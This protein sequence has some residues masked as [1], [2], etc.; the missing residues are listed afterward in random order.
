MDEEK[1]ARDILEEKDPKSLTEGEHV[2][3]AL[4]NLAD[5]IGEFIDQSIGDDEE[6]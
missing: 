4:Y 2:A 3:L 5:T 6:D 1:I